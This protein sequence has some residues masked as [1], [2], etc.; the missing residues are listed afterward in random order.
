MQSS[1]WDTK[2]NPSCRSTVGIA[3]LGHQPVANSTTTKS[4]RW[5]LDVVSMGMQ[6]SGILHTCNVQGQRTATRLIYIQVILM[7]LYFSEN[8]T[9]RFGL[10]SP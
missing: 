1:P 4:S 2:F 7:Q 8:I 5:R 3:A 10:T 6:C 9:R